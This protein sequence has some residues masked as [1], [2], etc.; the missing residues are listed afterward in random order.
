ML[1]FTLAGYMM[2]HMLVAAAS[3]CPL[4]QEDMK[5]TTAHSLMEIILPDIV[6]SAYVVMFY[7]KMEKVAQFIARK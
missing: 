3:N 4:Q 6:W 5:M 1:L 2:C 7:K